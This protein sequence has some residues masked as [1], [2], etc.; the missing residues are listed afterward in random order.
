MYSKDGACG[1]GKGS[2]PHDEYDSKDGYCGTSEEYCGIDC[3][4]NYSRCIKVKP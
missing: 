4:P 1:E 3:N 2:C